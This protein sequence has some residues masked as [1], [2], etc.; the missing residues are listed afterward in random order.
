MVRQHDPSGTNADALGSFGNVS[1]DDRGRSAGDTGKVV[2]FRQ[3]IAVVTPFLNVPGKIEGIAEGESGVAT[4]ND[5]GKIKDGEIFH[6]VLILSRRAREK[7]L[8]RE[9]K[10]RS[11]GLK[12]PLRLQGAQDPTH[13]KTAD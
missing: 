5:R 7:N 11:G 8:G 2:M 6:R 12:P 9:A 1:N 4:L 10:A 13:F 3:P